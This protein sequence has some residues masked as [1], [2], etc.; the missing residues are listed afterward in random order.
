MS[1]AGLGPEIGCC[2]GTQQQSQSQ[3]YFTTDG[4]SVS[5]SWCPSN[6]CKLQTLVPSERALHINSPSTD[7]NKHQRSTCKLLTAHRHSSTHRQKKGAINYPIRHIQGN[8]KIQNIR[9]TSQK[10]KTAS[11]MLYKENSYLHLH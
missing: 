10:F 8:L 4:Q 9:I 6:S 3:S 5:M 1:P 2:G 11:T 7:I